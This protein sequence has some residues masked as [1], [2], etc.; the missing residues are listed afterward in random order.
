MIKEA[1]ENA[2]LD[3][4]KKALVNIN[5]ELDN[6]ISKIEKFYEKSSSV[7]TIA[8][9]Y[10]KESL[11]EL[12]ENYLRNKLSNISPSILD[13]LKYGY[14]II[15]LDYFKEQLNSKITSNKSDDKGSGVVIDVTGE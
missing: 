11:K 14:S 6:L 9:Q 10:L 15:V 2:A 12:K 4:S 5:Y 1:E 8:S 13:N 3:K 7:D